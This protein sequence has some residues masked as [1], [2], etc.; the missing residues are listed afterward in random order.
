VPGGARRR[1]AAVCALYRRP[2]HAL[3]EPEHPAELDRGDDPDPAAF[4]AERAD[5]HDALDVRRAG[6]RADPDPAR[7]VEGG[8]RSARDDPLAGDVGDEADPAAGT[9]RG[10]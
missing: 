3:D 9:E 6:L 10:W 1:D 7:A 4:V 8:H 5:R 2:R